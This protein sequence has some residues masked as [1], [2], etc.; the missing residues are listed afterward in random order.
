[1]DFD[2]IQAL[3]TTLYDTIYVL[4]LI[5]PGLASFGLHPPLVPVH[6]PSGHSYFA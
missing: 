5:V 6:P 3:L 2:S 1:M 4:S